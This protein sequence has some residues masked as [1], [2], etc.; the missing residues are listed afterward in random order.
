MPIIL[1]ASCS[2]S[3]FVPAEK[4]GGVWANYLRAAKPSTWAELVGLLRERGYFSRDE[5]LAAALGVRAN[6]SK[7]KN[8]GNYSLDAIRN[9]VLPVIHRLDDPSSKLIDDVERTLFGLGGEE[10]GVV[11][12]DTSTMPARDADGVLRVLLHHLFGRAVRGLTEGG[13]PRRGVLLVL[14]EAQTVLSGRHLD[15]QDIYVR[16]VKEGRK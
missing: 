3:S 12:L 8:E 14:E 16:W 10:P 4:R 1:A 5:E 11:I 2:A 13:A 15:D 9:N 6:R 7:D